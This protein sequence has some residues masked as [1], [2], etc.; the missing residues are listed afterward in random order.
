MQNVFVAG[1]D[2]SAVAMEWAMS[3]LINRPLVME[4]ARQEIDAVIGKSRIVEESDIVN[5]PYLQAIIKETFR[6]HPP[7]PLIPRESSKRDMVC[8][9]DIPAKTRLFVNI[10][11]IGRDP[12]LWESPLEFKPE[13]FMGQEGNGLSQ[14]DVRGQHYQLIPF[15]SGR[16]GCPGSSLALPIVHVNLAALIQCF[17]WKVDD[18]R[19]KVDMEETPGLT[20]RRAHPIIY[21]PVPKLNPFPSI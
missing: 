14:L 11:A 5:L 21:A 15:G 7:A 6:L 17:E 2:T 3:E 20:V 18:G 12:K 8:G 1:T 13:R 19:E 9:Y 16:R 10:W 4:K